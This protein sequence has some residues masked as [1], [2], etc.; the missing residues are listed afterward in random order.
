MLVLVI[1]KINDADKKKIFVL[2]K[3]DSNEYHKNNWIITCTKKLYLLKYM[4][5]L[6]KWESTLRIM[7]VTKTIKSKMTSC[8]LL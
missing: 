8:K 5:V 3:W 6:F 1:L 7:R 2:Y 4:H